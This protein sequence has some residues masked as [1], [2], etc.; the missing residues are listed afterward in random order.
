MDQSI[1]IKDKIAETLEENCWRRGDGL[2]FCVCDMFLN[3]TPKHGQEKKH[4]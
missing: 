1:H 3:M 4:Q 2:Q